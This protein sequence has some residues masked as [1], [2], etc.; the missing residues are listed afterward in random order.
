MLLPL[1]RQPFPV[2]AERKGDSVGHD[3]AL[4]PDG[5][6]LAGYNNYMARYTLHLTAIRPYF[7]EIP[8]ALWGEVDYDSDGDCRDPNDREWTELTV[9]NRGTSERVDIV[10]IGAE[11]IVES[12]DRQ[13]A[14]R[15][16][17]YLIERAGAT[18]IDEDPRSAVGA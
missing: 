4:R 1:Y 11:F 9:I 18:P 2:Q 5:T 3:L 13:L 14:A 15:A 12:D 8:Y 17:T 10:S 16:A 6:G 7:W